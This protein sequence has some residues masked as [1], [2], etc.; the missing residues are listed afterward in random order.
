MSEKKTLL[1]NEVL[2]QQA[3][4][5]YLDV[6]LR[7]ATEQN[8]QPQIE[9]TI[10]ETLP[11]QIAEPASDA[12]VLKAEAPKVGSVAT[13]PVSEKKAATALKT[14]TG[15]ERLKQL[16]KK[17]LAQRNIEVKSPPKESTVTKVPEKT[18][19][20][21]PQ[22]L[23]APVVKE[24]VAQKPAEANS[25]SKAPSV[26]VNGRP[27]WAQ[28]HFQCLLFEVAGLT[29]AVPLVTLGTIYPVEFDDLTPL[30]GQPNWFMGLLPVQGSNI[31]VV[32]TALW[33]MPDRYTEDVKSG[34]K[35]VVG[36]AGSDWGMACHS[37]AEAITLQPDQVRWRTARG[38][39]PWLA[40]TVIDHMCAL[41]DVEALSGLLHESGARLSH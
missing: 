21:K 26:W 6:M 24:N 12:K 29:L 10:T 4:Q 22:A 19:L 2:P 37:V 14:T 8:T 20:E 41:M 17:R 39:R 31:K 25:S 11:T 16:L 40:G 27:P 1:E 13:E 5:N 34:S 35:Y 23:V 9:E 30:F 36:I 18:A 38:A 28:E 32:D 3:L 33:V 7:D 15:R